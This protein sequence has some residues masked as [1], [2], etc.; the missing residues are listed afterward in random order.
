MEQALY[1]V[2][3]QLADGD[4]CLDTLKGIWA[5]DRLFSYDAFKRTAEFCA[6]RMT[7]AG[8]SQVERLPI[9]A[10][11]T[12]VYGDWVI[13]R[14]WDAHS[15][16]LEVVSPA[17]AAP[18]L[19]AYPQ[20]PCSL[21]M[22]SGA[23]PPV[24]T[25]VLLADQPETLA[26]ADCKDKLLLTD[27]RPQALAGF[28]KEVG[29]LGILSDAIPLYPGVRDRREDLYDT[30]RWENAFCLPHNEAGLVSF[31][32]TPR[33]G[34]LLRGLLTRGERVVL[35]AQVD[36]EDYAGSV[37]TVSALLPGR[38]P[39]AGEV[40]GFGH[41]CEPGAHDNA[42]GCALLI[43]AATVL[44]QA[45]EE[46][47]LPR[48][49][50]GIRIGMGF[51]C[52]GS[53]GYA[54]HHPDRIAKTVAG[55]V[56]DMVGTQE[57]D[58]TI[59][60]YWHNP[61]ANWGLTDAL[62]VSMTHAV[63]QFSGVTVPYE[64]RRFNIG[65]DNILGDPWFGMPTVAIIA[66][67][68][69]SYHSSMDSPDRIDKAVLRRNVLIAASYL[70]TLANL[71]DDSVLPLARLVLED[72]AARAAQKTGDLV[73]LTLEAAQ[74]AVLALKGFVK[75]AETC[76]ALDELAS[77]LVLPPV[78]AL[79]SQAAPDPVGEKHPVRLVMGVL[80]MEAGEALPRMTAEERE[81]WQPGWSDELNTPLFWADGNRSLWE[82][83]VR[84]GIELSVEDI[85]GYYA[86]LRDYFLFLDKYGYVRLDG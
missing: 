86:T 38:D 64:E 32:L 37:D 71:D 5:N 77:S 49:L 24:E 58:R 73:Y 22:Y 41:L 54:H 55:L 72:G 10:D 81:R 17:V 42:S 46:G 25:E 80:N 74:R 35:R 20:I 70:Y 28:A 6:G 30:H 59:N 2:L 21:V 79:L 52:G 85:P 65:T 15:A 7:A 62:M 53:M 33:Q 67:P 36:A 76:K 66:E 27:K 11:G 29:A 57:I 47:L 48:P 75:Q 8:L 16:R 23:T 61:L 12:A 63:E 78:P 14:A 1:Q 26:G 18:L 34:D 9:V 50:R 56:A 43:E 68:A 69:L 83:A 31:S 39:E 45:V 3:D 44:A 51:E 4:R 19:C 40:M 84:S 13:P 60:S 82:I